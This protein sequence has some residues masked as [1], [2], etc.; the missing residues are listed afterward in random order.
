MFLPS[1]HRRVL[2][3]LLASAALVAAPGIVRGDVP[4]LA[5]PTLLPG[6][7]SPAASAANQNAPYVARGGGGYLAVWA[8]ARTNLFYPPPWSEEQG[9]R[10]IYAARLDAS[11]FLVDTIPF[12]VNQD[13][14]WQKNP[15]AAWN[16]QCWLVVWETQAPTEFYY[17]SAIYAARVAPDGTVLDPDPIHVIVYPYSSSAYFS[18]ASDGSQWVVVAEGSSA[19]ENGIFGVRVGADG[20]V[21]DP[22][23][24][25]LV[26]EAYYLNFSIRVQYAD[27]EYLLTYDA[28]GANKARRFTPDLAPIGLPY[29]PRSLLTQSD[30]TG[31]YAAWVSGG[32][33]VGSPMSKTGVLMFPSGIPL[34]PSATA[35]A[36]DLGWDG[37]RW[38]F[39]TLHS[40]QGMVAR[41]IASNGTVLDPAGI[42]VDPSATIFTTQELAIEGGLAGGAVLAWHDLRAGGVNPSDVYAGAISAAGA[43]RAGSPIALGAP[44]QLRPDVA[45]GDGFLVAFRR[46]TSG[47]QQVMFQRLDAAGQPV[48][49]AP[50]ALGGGSQIGRTSVAWNGS[51]YFVVWSESGVIRGARVLPDG[52][53]LD[54]TPI[55]IMPGITPD[56]AGLGDLFLVVGTHYP[57]GN[58]EVRVPVAARVSALSGAV[59]DPTPRVLGILFAQN[60]SV[61][62]CQGRWVAFWQRNLSHDDPI[63]VL[64]GAFVETGGSSSPEFG[65]PTTLDGGYTPAVAFSG[66]EVLVVYRRGSEGH[67]ATDIK[68]LR[69]LPDGVFPAGRTG[70]VVS[71]AVDEQLN[72]AVSWNGSEFLL[73][74]E[75]NRNA[76]AFFDE[77]TD[78][79]AARVSA[80]GAVLDPAGFPVA[81]SALP[82]QLPALAS[83]GGTS[84]IA[85]S[86][87]QD[88]AP[89]ASYR[90]GTFVSTTGATSVAAADPDG[91][92]GDPARGAPAAWRTVPNPYRPGAEVRYELERSERVSLRIYD[93]Q[94][95]LVR[96]LQEPAVQAAGLHS[97]AWEGTDAGGRRAP[98]SVYFL[99]MEAES[100]ARTTRLVLAR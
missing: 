93:A 29:T 35:L 15:Q 82:E 23:P 75:D 11:G 61:T 17:A 62:A 5:G 6:D 49:S 13:F 41:R 21:L 32:Q 24:K 99:R 42:V 90:V 68:A 27:G 65:Y 16:G 20:G 52:T 67:F 80:G 43:P 28:L 1:L 97:I 73:V 81:S 12:V 98:S 53:V 85:A 33:Y 63:A 19:G 91:G 44:A 22:A 37:A 31:Y 92:A 71:A 9:A 26:P 7:L 58:P 88:R 69:M 64:S 87:F 3:A 47:S 72:P 34:A 77:R 84:V 83:L 57:S 51:L 39:A 45:A 10:D 70:F 8:D 46:E 50:V 76:A 96:S 2:V 66:S 40:T 36:V 60:P 56:V 55:A 48:D 86:L 38:W 30:G 78:I 14:G 54:A 4:P 95:R 59:L 74:W 79:Y 25:V 94:G 100:A 18:V 89:Y